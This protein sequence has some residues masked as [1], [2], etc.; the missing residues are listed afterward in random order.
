MSWDSKSLIVLIL[1]WALVTVIY[2][3]AMDMPEATRAWGAGTALF[4]LIL[5][6]LFWAE[7]RGTRRAGAEGQGR[8]DEGGA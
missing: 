1:A 8:D 3:T 6:G 7:R 2:A 5:L 4:V